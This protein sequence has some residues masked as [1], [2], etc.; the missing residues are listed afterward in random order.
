[1][2]K[3]NRV[4]EATVVLDLRFYID[5]DTSPEDVLNKHNLYVNSDHGMITEMKLAHTS[6]TRDE[7]IG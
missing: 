7:K 4:I 1:M 5:E 2:K 6:I 3:K